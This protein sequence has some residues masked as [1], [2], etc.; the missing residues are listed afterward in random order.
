MQLEVVQETCAGRNDLRF[1]DLNLKSH[2]RAQPVGLVSFA[3]LFLLLFGWFVFLFCFVLLWD[4]SCPHVGTRISYPGGDFPTQNSEEVSVWSI[5]EQKATAGL[6][7][8]PDLPVITSSHFLLTPLE[9][10][11]GGQCFLHALS[12]QI[13]LHVSFLKNVILL[14]LA[15]LHFLHWTELWG[16]STSSQ[17]P[18]LAQREGFNWL[19]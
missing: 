10:V 5:Q 9:V 4:L 3:C 2:S 11:K 13:L 7:Q 6:A 14:F 16:C 8:I 1:R 12:N 18:S 17:S 19:W 15:S